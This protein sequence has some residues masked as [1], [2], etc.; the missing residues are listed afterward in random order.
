MPQIH[1]GGCRC[2]A[3]RF[4][5]NLTGAHT[6]VCH[7][8]DCQQHLGAPFSVFTQVPSSQFKWIS[9]PTGEIAFSNSAV[10]RFCNKCGT[11][12]KWEGNDSP[13]EAE[14]NTLSLDNPARVAVDEEIYTRSR[15]DWVQPINGV[16]QH[17]AGRH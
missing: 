7:C 17:K 5:V 10:R 14:F 15:L 16:R 13:D 1:E 3:S 2:G 8:R 11:Y 12:L 9:E 4:Q 6:L